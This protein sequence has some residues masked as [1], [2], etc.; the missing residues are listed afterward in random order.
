MPQGDISG[1]NALEMK[2]GIQGR[3]RCFIALTGY[4][5]DTAL[6]EAHQPGLGRRQAENRG[7]IDRGNHRVRD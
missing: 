6:V 4:H 7:E 3:D 1:S 5:R 2:G